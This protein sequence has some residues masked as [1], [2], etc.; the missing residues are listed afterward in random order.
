[1]NRVQ[2]YNGVCRPSFW[3][4]ESVVLVQTLGLAAA[5]VFANSLNAFFQLLIMAIILVIG[6]LALAHFQPFQQKGSQTVQVCV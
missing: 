4:W 1:M 5:Q 3:F 2:L 6:S